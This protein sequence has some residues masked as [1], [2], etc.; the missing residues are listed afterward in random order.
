M[1]DGRWFS[2]GRLAK[3]H[4]Q[5]SLGSVL[6]FF[7]R[8]IRHRFDMIVRKTGGG[9]SSEGL[10]TTAHSLPFDVAS[11]PALGIFLAFDV[12]CLSATVHAFAFGVASPLL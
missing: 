4:A 9:N 1:E 8:S 3:R 11:L 10:S 12:S 5:P 2:G 6:S 7:Y